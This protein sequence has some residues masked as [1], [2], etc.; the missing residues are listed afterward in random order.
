M[1]GKVYSMPPQPPVAEN[2][3]KI[4]AGAVTFGVEYR[5]L[6]PQGLIETYK[7]NQAHLA[8]LLEKSP[9]GGFTDEGVSIHVWGSEDGHEYLRFDMFDGEP[10]YHY[11]HRSADVVN[12]VIDYDTAALGE[13]LPWVVERLRTRLPDMLCESGGAEVAAGLDLGLVAGA[14]GEVERL[15]VAAQHQQRALRPE[16]TS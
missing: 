16:P 13:M 5:D 8:E 9:E 7:D 10:H 14:I 12:N 2:T 15:A 4:P 3:R 1:I 11:V 6:D